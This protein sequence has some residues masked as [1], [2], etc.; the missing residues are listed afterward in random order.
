MERPSDQRQH[1]ADGERP[2]SGCV[3]ILGALG[4]FAVNSCLWNER[5]GQL[6][7][8]TPWGRSSESYLMEEVLSS[9]GGQGGFNRVLKLRVGGTQI[10]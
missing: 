2:L 4:V 3:G 8:E 5:V 6:Q 10:G 7:F 9:L 1:P